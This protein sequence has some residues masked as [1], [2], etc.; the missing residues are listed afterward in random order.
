MEK[1]V[2][3]HVRLRQLYAG[4]A[5]EP[6]NDDARDDAERADYDALHEIGQR[7]SCIRSAE[8]NDLLDR[9]V[10][11]DEVTRIQA[12]FAVADKVDLIDPPAP[13]GIGNFGGNLAGIILD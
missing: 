9:V 7:A 6:V 3:G 8:L 4:R 11:F 13:F 10:T 5:C 12:A 1:I 2:P